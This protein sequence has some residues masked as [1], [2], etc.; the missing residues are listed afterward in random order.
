VSGL[1]HLVGMV[2]LLPLPGSP[3]F[4][5]SMD[6]VIEAAVADARTL[7]AA[8]FPGILI[9]NY[10]DAPFRGDR[11]DP[12]TIAAMTLAVGAAR[13]ETSLPVGV[14]VLRNDAVAAL[15]IVAAT[16]AGF[17]RVNVLT[18]VMYTDQGPLAGRAA[19][20]LRRRAV[21]APEVEVWADVMVK[22]AVPPPGLTADQAARDTVERGLADAVIVSGS[23]TGEE[24]DLAESSAIASAVPK[25]T[26]VVIG[27]GAAPGNLGRLLEIADT[28]IV[29]SA[30]K[31]DNDPRNA[32][33]PGRASAFVESAVANGLI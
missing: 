18:G 9:E 29:G 11:V 13:A 22:H 15:G 27:S 6:R 12:E 17:I 23:G 25:G 2:H 20:L 14:N 30:L 5:G 16:G 3:R 19:E 1:P 21:L 33:D 32:V 26:R 4:G 7:H 31:V 28:V 24:P 8:G 10:G